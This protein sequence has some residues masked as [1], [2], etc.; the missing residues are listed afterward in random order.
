MKSYEQENETLKSIYSKIH[1]HPFSFYICTRLQISV[2]YLQTL[3]FSVPFR[4]P[5]LSGS[6]VLNQYISKM[7]LSHKPRQHVFKQ[8]ALK[9]FLIN[10]PPSSKSCVVLYWNP[11]RLLLA[12]RCIQKERKLGVDVV[13][14]KRLSLW[15]RLVS[16][17][18]MRHF[19][20]CIFILRVLLESAQVKARF[21]I[22]M[23]QCESKLFTTLIHSKPRALQESRVCM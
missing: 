14:R 10:V 7:F 19:M 23:L 20:M 6:W 22:R 17:P 15:K 12:D 21:P 8:Q 3:R 9:P 16:S 13:G 4:L 1:S 11:P 5:E 18:S 2:L